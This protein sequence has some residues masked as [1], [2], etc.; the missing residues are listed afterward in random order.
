MSRRPGKSVAVAGRTGQRIG[1]TACS[2]NQD[3]ASNGA[4]VLG[5]HAGHLSV[6]TEDIRHRIAQDTHAAVAAIT[7]QRVVDIR[8]FVRYRKHT[9]APFHLQSHTPLLKKS[10][11]VA[12]A[13][14]GKSA[15][16]KLGVDRDMTEKNVTVAVVGDVAAPLSGNQQ[17]FAV[18]G[19]LFNQQN[20]S[21]PLPRRSRCHHT[22]GTAADDNE[23]GCGHGVSSSG[24]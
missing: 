2:D 14:P 20:R 3:P 13:E 23:F 5:L 7:D 1:K 8:R 24:F 18:A 6:L 11:D 19:I 12:V 17:L 10:H 4:V 15:V 9:A 21:T 22:R 16:K